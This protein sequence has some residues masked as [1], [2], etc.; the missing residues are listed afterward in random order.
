M[1]PPQKLNIDVI[2]TC[3]SRNHTSQQNG[4]ENGLHGEAGVE[5]RPGIYYVAV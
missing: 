4:E 1:S 5:L 2:F 3:C